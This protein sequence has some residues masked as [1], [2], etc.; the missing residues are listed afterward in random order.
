MK[1]AILAV[2]IASFLLTFCACQPTNPNL[3]EK[4]SGQN[5]ENTKSSQ[6]SE[7]SSNLESNRPEAS[8]GESDFYFMAGSVRL[9]LPSQITSIKDV[10][11]EP[12]K[13]EE[14]QSC[15]SN[16]KDKTFEYDGYALYT[17]PENEKDT[18]YLIE[19]FDSSVSTPAGAKVGQSFSEIEAIYGTGWEAKGLTR[20]YTLQGGRSLCFTLRD[21]KVDLIEYILN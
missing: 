10:L 12:L 8:F 13:Y 16:G 17:R 5:S 9:T 4:T 20:V 14:A 6:S 11:G 15:Y 1:Q 7:S 2:L 19:L 3:P 18:L 21:D